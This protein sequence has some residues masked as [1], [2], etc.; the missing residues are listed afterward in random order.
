MIRKNTES[1]VQIYRPANYVRHQYDGDCG[2]F[3]QAAWPAAY[4]RPLYPAPENVITRRT[5]FDLEK[6]EKREH[7]L[8]G[9]IIAV[10]ISTV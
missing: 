3:A 4:P 9:L 1:A 10:K 6:A 8:L 5:Q 7:I 2:R